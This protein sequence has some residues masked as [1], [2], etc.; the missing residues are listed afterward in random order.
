MIYDILILS[1]KKNFNNLQLLYNSL[2]YLKPTYNKVYC[3][4]PEY[5]SKKI[6]GI[7][8]LLDKDVLNISAPKIR[9]NWIYQ[10]YIKLVQD[11]TL[12]N[13]LVIDAD[14]ILN[15]N[16]E[17]ITD[18]PNFLISNSTNNRP[19]FKWMKEMFGFEKSYDK[20]FISEIMM[21]DRKIVKEFIPNTTEFIEKSNYILEQDCFLSEYELYGNYVYI[22]HKDKYNYKHIKMSPLHLYKNHKETLKK[23]IATHKKSNFDILSL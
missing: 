21:F 14:I 8:Y 7:I 12:D 15:K 3:V 10:Q 22:N 9:P 13:Y 23:F 18:K 17:I 4:C 2:V 1:A 16:I 11:V 6:K 5:P 19:F 20:S